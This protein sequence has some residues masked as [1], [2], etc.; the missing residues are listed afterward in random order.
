MKDVLIIGASGAV[1]SAL[2]TRL[3]QDPEVNRI[4]IIARR[5]LSQLP[6]KCQQLIFNELKA[7]DLSNLELPGIHQALC[8]LGTTIAQAG[9]QHNFR[10]V[11]YDLVV[12][13]G[14][15]VARNNI[16][17]LHVI[18]AIGANSSAMSF[19]SRVKGEAE[20]ALIALD[21]EQLWLY[22][23]S[24]LINADRPDFRLAETVAQWLL[25]PLNIL[26]IGK[27][28]SG[29]D[30]KKVAAAMHYFSTQQAEQKPQ[31]ISSKSMHRF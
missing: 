25:K 2:L 12:A 1:G 18:S 6:S 28:F 20:E 15:L 3:C 24:L 17:S 9:S 23:P 11:D 29:I 14:Q 8:C 30:V 22:R 21:I 26:N 7:S 5:P 19:Y 10:A 16:P 13:F 27:G 4:H 31:I